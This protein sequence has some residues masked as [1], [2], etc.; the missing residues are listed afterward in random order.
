ML[1]WRRCLASGS[2]LLVLEDDVIFGGAHVGASVLALA[3]SIEETFAPADREILLYLGADAYFREGA[4]SLRGKQAIWAARG[5]NAPCVLKEAE[6]A[7]QTQSYVIWPAAARVLLAGLPMD[8]PVDV[9]LSRHFTT[10][11]LSGLVASPQLAT[12][13][14]PYHGGDVAHSSLKGRPDWGARVRTG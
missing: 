12:Q 13:I 5:A 11:T 1:L 10:R 9:Y 14:D 3:R 4:P 7:W 2:A 8:A 6:W